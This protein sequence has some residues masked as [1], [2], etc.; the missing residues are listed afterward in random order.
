MPS[1]ISKREGN[2]DF[3]VLWPGS[4]PGMQVPVPDDL[5]GPI[6]HSINTTMLE[7]ER[8][9]REVAPTDISV[10]I[11]GES[12]SGKEILAR[13][14]FCCSN[15]TDKPFLKVHCGRLGQ[16]QGG[17]DSL[18]FEGEPKRNCMG[19][20]LLDAIDELALPLQQNLLE[21]LDTGDPAAWASGNRETAPWRVIA[22]SS[23]E[24]N[25]EIRKA[26]F[27]ADLYYRLSGV[28]LRLPPLRERREDIEPLAMF[29]LERFSE[30]L[31]R[32]RKMSLSQSGLKVLL[33]Y[34][35]P[36]NIRELENV[37]R[38]VVVLDDEEQALKS[39][40]EAMP[41][42]TPHQGHLC[43]A[44]NESLSLKKAT[45]LA[46]RDVEKELIT[47]ALTK[48]HWNRKQAAQELGIS[49]KALL[50][51]LRQLGLDG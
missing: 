25:E 42:S 51:K 28:C 30:A 26:R 15:R 34:P 50:Y 17:V 23:R 37:I 46:V 48:T 1:H 14:V 13:Q 9:A 11:F 24:L 27:R 38:R 35:W 41:S 31:G 7:V 45:H 20:L 8:I 49:Y 36:G 43:A 44:G 12:G 32:R 22:T 3:D 19:T 4:S 40:S 21:L 18:S 10:L 16:A 47:K 6:V 5:L 29:F 2:V 39:L 33:N